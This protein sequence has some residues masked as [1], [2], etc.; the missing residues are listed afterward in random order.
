[1]LY[2]KSGR[3]RS[4]TIRKHGQRQ[5]RSQRERGRDGLTGA[6][7]KLRDGDRCTERRG[8]TETELEAE[9]HGGRARSYIR[10]TER[11]SRD[12]W[13]RGAAQSRASVCE[14]QGE[15]PNQQKKTETRN[16]PQRQLPGD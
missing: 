7:A 3:D 5:R 6:Y 1:M 13:T 12:T 4:G 2:A 15:D 8:E 11:Q 9:M 10:G 16:T 14:Y